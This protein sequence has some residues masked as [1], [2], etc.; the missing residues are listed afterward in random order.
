MLAQLC[1][2]GSG[3]L[4]VLIHARQHAFGV[5]LVKVRVIA[6]SDAELRERVIRIRGGKVILLSL[7]QE[8]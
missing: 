2:L 1:L 7:A 6:L 3:S 5:A 4:E 8:S